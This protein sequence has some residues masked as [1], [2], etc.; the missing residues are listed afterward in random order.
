MNKDGNGVQ[1]GSNK[2][3][4]IFRPVIWFFRAIY[5]LIRKSV[6]AILLVAAVLLV[7]MLYTSVAEIKEDK[8][9][10]FDYYKDTLLEL[11]P[12]TSQLGA[13][14]DNLMTDIIVAEQDGKITISEFVSIENG[15]RALEALSFKVALE[16]A[17]QQ[18]GAQSAE[19]TAEQ[20]EKPADDKVDANEP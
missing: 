9:I 12:A 18:K 6:V 19:K 10:L 20:S 2:I 14:K 1:P 4:A 17:N 8:K 15:Y 11:Q 5:W 16:V 3:N 7:S 13:M